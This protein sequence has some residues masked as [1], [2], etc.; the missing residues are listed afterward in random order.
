[1]ASGERVFFDTNILIDVICQREPF[2]ADSAKAW[3]LAESG[4]MRGILGALSYTTVYYV[5]SRTSG[6]HRAKAGIQMLNAV[7]TTATCDADVL[8]KAIASQMPDFEDAVQFFS[9]IAAQADVML[10]RN[11]VDF[12]RSPLKVLTPTDY[13]NVR[14]QR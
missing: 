6:R 1:M 10:T 8:R 9:A 14:L 2:L 3:S 12:P 11:V 13:L 5:V 4:E 7:F